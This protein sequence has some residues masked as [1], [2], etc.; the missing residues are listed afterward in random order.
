MWPSW[1]YVFL[2]IFYLTNDKESLQ[3][4]DQ[5]SGKLLWR[6][7]SWAVY[8]KPSFKAKGLFYSFFAMLSMFEF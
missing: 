2:G 8:G 1:E 6:L 7:D 3:P 5:I 4:D